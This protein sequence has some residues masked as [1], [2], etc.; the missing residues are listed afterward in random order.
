[1]SGSTGSFTDMRSWGG[2]LIATG[3][4]SLVADQDHWLRP[5]GIAAWDG[6]HWSPLGDGV[7]GQYFSLGEYAGDLVV[8]GY[9]MSIRGLPITRAARW[10]GA[11]WSQIGT[12]APDFVVSVAEFQ[13]QL[14]M[15]SEGGLWHWDNSTWSSVPVLDGQNVDAIAP[16]GPRLV[17][18]G[19]IAQGGAIGSPNVVFWDGTNL[20]PAGAGVNSIVLAATEWLGQPVIGGRF[21]AS[22][23]TP[24]PGV[25]T[26]DGSQWQP[27]GTRAVEVYQLRVED[28]ELFASGDFRL[29]DDSVVE[30]IAHWTGTDWHV[31]GSGSNGYAFATYGGYLYQ[32]GSGLVHGHVSHG[33]SR[34]PLGAVLD[35]PQPQAAARIALSVSPNPARGPAGFYF[36][37]PS[38]GHARVT[39]LDLAGRR[40]ATLADGAFEAGPHRAAWT[41]PG[42]PGVYLAL[43]ETGAGRVSRRFVVLE[44]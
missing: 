8:A 42:A 27:M 15:G 20:E 19:S 38:A 6:T 4:F 17:V 14:Y 11:S 44:R 30:T 18:G 16:S 10:N 41:T 1:M 5:L 29:P 23:A 3:I 13:N 37:L 36:T 24:L 9:S 43:L 25:A 7:N 31:L 40:V 22:G 28:G 12:G 39:V 34:V 21:T 35:V 26:W 2:K 33:L 32:A